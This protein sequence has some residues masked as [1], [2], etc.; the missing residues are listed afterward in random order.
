MPV[1]TYLTEDL[2]SYEELEEVQHNKYGTV[3][4]QV[5]LN[6]IIAYAS[7]AHAISLIWKKPIS[8]TAVRKVGH[9]QLYAVN[10]R[11][12]ASCLFKSY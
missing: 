9:K 10:I 4:V 11:T 8:T 3:P 7:S 1:A 6:T 12:Y 5:H 2:Q